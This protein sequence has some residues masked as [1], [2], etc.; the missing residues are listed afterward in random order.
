MHLS[1]LKIGEV[2]IIEKIELSNAQHK[3]MN[4]GCVPGERIQILFSAPLG[5]PIAVKVSGYTL[6]MRKAEA[7]AIKVK[8]L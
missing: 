1:E 2:A 5:D 7:S 4:M 6:S 3:L 8:M